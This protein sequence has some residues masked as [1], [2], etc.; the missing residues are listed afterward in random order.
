MAGKAADEGGER[1]IGSL[2]EAL[3]AAGRSEGAPAHAANEPKALP[4]PPAPG[5]PALPAAAPG[6]TGTA[7]ERRTGVP[8]AAEAALEA[9]GGEAP[10]TRAV[11][12]G[13]ARPPL[14]GGP[15]RTQLVRGKS[16]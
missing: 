3:A 12:A 7:T 6:S 2:R 4:Q 11:R 1:R 13:G 8:S 16:P 9:R 10:Q 15:A 14:P 5:V